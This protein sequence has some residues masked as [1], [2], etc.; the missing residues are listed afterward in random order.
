MSAPGTSAGEP[1]PSGPPKRSAPATQVGLI[2]AAVHPV[3]TPRPDVT[4][5][6]ILAELGRGGMSVVYLARQSGLG[7]VVALKMLGAVGASDAAAL[8]RFRTEAEAVARLH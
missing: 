1:S 4:G 8:A 3:E 2:H 6:E 5:Y 7:R